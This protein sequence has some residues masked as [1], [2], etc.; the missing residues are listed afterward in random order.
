M[1]VELTIF[2]GNDN[3]TLYKNFRCFLINILVVLIGYKQQIIHCMYEKDPPVLSK[4]F[5]EDFFDR[6]YPD[7]KICIFKSCVIY[8]FTLFCPFANQFEHLLSLALVYV[9]SI[10]I[11][12]YYV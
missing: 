12:K 8:F 11:F 4:S 2:S 5:C 3:R 9:K 7:I 10:F 1:Q 6:V